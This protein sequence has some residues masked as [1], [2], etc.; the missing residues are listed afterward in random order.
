MDRDGLCAELAMALSRL[1]P[2]RATLAFELDGT[3]AAT[4]DGHAD[5]S[6]LA[7]SAQRLQAL[8]SR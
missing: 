6:I 4:C 2:A 8:A 5:M 1:D 7:P 3:N